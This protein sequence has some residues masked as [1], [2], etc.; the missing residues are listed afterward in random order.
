MLIWDNRFCNLTAPEGVSGPFGVEVLNG[1]TIKAQWKR[2]TGHT[3][4]ILSY[5]LK[6]IDRDNDTAEPVLTEFTPET[7]SGK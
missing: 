3:G 6:A 7:Y 2:P 1:F 5:M 4:Q